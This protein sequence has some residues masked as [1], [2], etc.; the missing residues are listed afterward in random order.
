ME[1]AR[2]RGENGVVLAMKGDF[3]VAVARELREAL[4]SAFDEK[5]GV[6]L[7]VAGVEDADITFLQLLIAADAFAREQGRR[8]SLTGPLPEGV[9]RA[10]LLSGV[11]RCQE[12]RELLSRSGI[13]LEV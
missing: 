3:T 10:A 2:S 8:L 4:S 1:I 11:N 13:T 12:F 5:G 6:V 9:A 7:D